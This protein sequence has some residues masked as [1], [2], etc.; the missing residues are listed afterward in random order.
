VPGPFYKGGWQGR[1]IR[2]DRNISTPSGFARLTGF[3]ACTQLVL[4]CRVATQ[5]SGSTSHVALG[6]AHTQALGR[7]KLCRRSLI[8]TGARPHHSYTGAPSTSGAASLQKPRDATTPAGSA[9]RERRRTSG[10]RR[11]ATRLGTRSGATGG[12]RRRPRAQR[13]A[14]QDS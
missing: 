10:A 7:S 9:E 8:Q 14:T 3:P 4:A 2:P 12:Q 13:L 11:P 5:C 1:T 6:R